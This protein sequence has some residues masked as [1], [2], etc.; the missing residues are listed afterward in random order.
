MDYA[1]RTTINKWDLIKV[2]SFCKAGTWSIG[3][4]WQL[5]D[6]EKIFTNPISNRELISKIYQKKR[7]HKQTNK[8]TKNKTK[9]QKNKPTKKTSRRQTPENQIIL[10]TERSIE[11]NREFSIEES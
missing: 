8:Q 2:Q 6:W 7:K 11:L 1:L 5:T 9:K 10:F 3:Q 4:K